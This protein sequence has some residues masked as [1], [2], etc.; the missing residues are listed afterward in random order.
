MEQLG[1]HRRLRRR[2][3]M[4]KRIS[5]LP[6]DI[7]HRIL[8]RIGSVPAAARTCVLSRQWR[9]VWADLPE[10]VFHDYGPLRH[11][12]FLNSVDGALAHY[13]A[14]TL[15]LLYI[16]M[17]NVASR[18]PATLIS[19]W[20][21][22]ASERVAGDLLLC[23]PWHPEGGEEEDLDLPLCVRARRIQL[24]IGHGFRR[25]RLPRA[26]TFAALTSMTIR[27]ATIDFR[28]LETV[29]CWQCPCLVELQLMAISLVAVS[30]ITIRS[31][32]L[33]RLHF[34]VKNASRLVLDTLSI[35]D[36]I[37]SKL[38]KVSVAAHPEFVPHCKHRGRHLRRL[39]VKGSHQVMPVLMRH[40]IIVDQ[41][42]LDLTVSSVS[43]I[44][45]S[46]Y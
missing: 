18:V 42:E 4:T 13:S 36:L 46:L 5:D 3:G 23:L 28:E 38:T 26:G 31:L 7:L 12:L 15:R 40:F 33:K 35:E 45:C 20:L 43:Q 24:S 30:D 11:N 44:I 6:D 9:G 14:G 10:L 2:H 19:R 34:E 17:F 39:V 1:A 29:V 22:F 37:L 21:L 16:S 25:L 41:L 32:L 27:D 8:L